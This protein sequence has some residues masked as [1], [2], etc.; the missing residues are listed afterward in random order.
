MRAHL[1]KPLD[2]ESSR[3]QPPT[4]LHRL[5]GAHVLASP[6]LDPPSIRLAHML[7]VQDILNHVL[8]LRPSPEVG[9][10]VLEEREGRKNCNDGAGKRG[11]GKGLAVGYCLRA[12]D[13]E[14]AC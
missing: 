9:V 12:A 4:Q 8:D 7:L 11:E 1:I 5:C 2:V 10:G 6:N 14:L 3:P 13:L